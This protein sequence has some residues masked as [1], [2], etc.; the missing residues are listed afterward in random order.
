MEFPNFQLPKLEEII[1]T[2]ILMVT[3]RTTV[4]DALAI[5]NKARKR[6]SYL[7]VVERSQLLG[8]LTE[9]DIV[10][11]SARELDFKRITLEEVMTSKV[12]TLRKSEFQDIYQIMS[13]LCQH[14]IRHL[15]IIDESEKLL[16]I[17]SSD[18]VYQAL[19]PSNML[20]LRSVKEAMSEC[21]L[22]ASPTAS[23]VSVSKLMAEKHQSCV[24]IA[25]CQ[26]STDKVIPLGIVTERDIVQFQLLGIDLKTTIV[27]TVMSSPLVCV[28]STDSLLEVQQQMKK[29]R[30]R[31]LVVTKESGELEGMIS[32]QDMLRVFDT[33]ELFGVIGTLKQEL[34]Q[35]TDHLQREIEQREKIETFLRENQQLL[36][37]FVRHAPAAIAMVDRE[38]RYLAV[39]DRWID[40]YELEPQDIIGRSHYEVFPDLP[41]RWK[42][43]HQVCLSGKAELLKCEEDSFVRT[44]G[45]TEWLRW[46]LLPWKNSAGEIGGLLMFSEVITERISLE[47]KLQSNE[48]QM[49]ATFEAMNDLILAIDLAENSV[50]IL[51]TQS[52]YTI[53]DNSF[54]QITRGIHDLIFSS[55]ETDY[56]SLI[57]QV[58]KTQQTIN[59]EHALK[60]DNLSIWFS[61][62]ISAVT[63]NTALW[64]ARDITHRK[65]ME[66]ELFAEKELAQVTLRS[67][68]N[69]V[70]TTDAEGKVKDVNPAAEKLT[71][72]YTIKSR[73]KLATEIFPIFDLHRRKPIPH[74]VSLAIQQNSVYKLE[75]D[76]LLI[77]KDGTEYAVEMTAAPIQDFK[78]ELIGV[79]MV[80]YDVTQSRKLARELSWQASHDSLT[81]L[82][83]R[84]QF[85]KQLDLAIINAREN[86]TNYVLCYL[87][88]DRFKIV[89][90]T[91]G[92]AAGDELLKQVTT[93][94]RKRI[95]TSDIFA[96]LGGD[97]F[98]LLLCQCPLKKAEDIANQLRQLIYNFRFVWQENM[99]R[100]GVSIGLV[101]IDSATENL[102]ELLSKADAA[103]YAAKEKGRNCIYSYDDTDNL[104]VQQQGE[105]HWV[106]QINQAL[107]ENLF[108]LYAQKIVPIK[109]SSSCDTN[110][111]SDREHF[112]QAESISD[113]GVNRQQQQSNEIAF[114]DAESCHYEIL[115]RLIDKSGKLITPGAFLPAAERYNLMPAIDRWVIATFLAG[116]EIYCQS[117]EQNKKSLNNIY[118]IN[119]S[120]ASI[121]SQDF[122]TFLQEQFARYDIPAKTICFEITETVAISNLNEAAKLIK[123]LKKT[124]CS[125]ALDDFG[126][127]M[128]SLNYLKN[129]PVDYLKIDGS[130][131]KNIAS[132]RVDYATVECFNHISKIMEIKTIAEFV[133][134]DAILRNLQ[135]IG[136]D[137]AQ[138]YGIERPQ[139]LCL[140]LDNIIAHK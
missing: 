94:L 8:I 104:V 102:V 9:K 18:S 81:G 23:L 41:P 121:N 22:Q 4:F 115:L 131:V 124:G 10:R 51:P 64:V 86:A 80:F 78:G 45:K 67:I 53:K 26:N 118:T 28:K 40:D 39:S 96:R 61:V 66:Q 34:K 134:D 7:L 137:Y 55:E 138:G 47:Q 107:E 119:L 93:L 31:R 139:P 123:Q 91:C 38:M 33:A 109:N 24:V 59:L 49:R 50:R 99:F 70:I 129:L 89:N 52:S 98:G 83:N 56:Q 82:Y 132:D 116:Y 30:V 120:G 85:E 14:Q 126:S 12:I 69:A 37:L 77:A 68:G 13:I 21:V 43:D 127:G 32:F 128:S 15:P 17:I 88:L 135:K 27:Q 35:Q 100:I 95:R 2:D 1:E 79:V 58:L 48:A 87:D 76:A 117:K 106:S 110:R 73:G 63:E 42:R 62:N 11:L 29:L 97:E 75:Q 84:H 25:E 44:S 125:I 71:G 133:E 19:N 130:F 36:E 60:I 112:S 72:R 65:N 74:P 46:E 5:M 111:Q 54:S 114:D 57:R 105:K 136:V 101:S 140:P 122:G 3:L 113:R 103:C 90:D 6:Y 108:C 20:R 92:H 16:G